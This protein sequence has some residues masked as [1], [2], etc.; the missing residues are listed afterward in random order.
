MTFCLTVPKALIASTISG[1]DRLS[2]HSFGAA[3]DINAELGKYWKWTGA[4]EGEVGAYDNVVPEEIVEAMER[5][6][7]IWGG[8]WNHF[9]GMH[10]EYRPEMILH[11]RMVDDAG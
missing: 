8:K 4:K 5:Y 11:G 6:G 3:I 7:F 10:F 9:D 2:S 1:T